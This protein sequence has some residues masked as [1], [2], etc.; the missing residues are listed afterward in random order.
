MSHG[1]IAD[2]LDCPIGTVKTN[3]A[4]SKTKLRHLLAA[5]NPQT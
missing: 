3:L 4:R 5:W 2:L 1:E